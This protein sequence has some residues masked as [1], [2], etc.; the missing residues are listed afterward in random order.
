MI[1]TESL[2]TII[3]TLVNTFRS[4]N[5]TDKTS[6]ALAKDFYF[7]L[8]STFDLQYGNLLLAASTRSQLQEELDNDWPFFTNNTQL[9]R[10]CSKDSDCEGTQDI[11]NRLGNSI[12]PRPYLI[13]VLFPL[14]LHNFWLNILHGKACKLQQN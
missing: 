8:A 2:R 9:V 1:S 12:S 7:V 14:Q 4:G 13:F 5:L 6:F 10:N 3:Q 11:L